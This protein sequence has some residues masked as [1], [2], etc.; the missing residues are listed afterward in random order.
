MGEITVYTL[1]TC[2][3]LI[4]YI[5]VFYEDNQILDNYLNMTKYAPY[6][7]NNFNEEW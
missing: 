3:W 1:F 4:W 2:A 7:L 5:K 6:R